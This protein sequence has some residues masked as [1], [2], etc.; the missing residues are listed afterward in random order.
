M[1]TLLLRDPQI[2]PE[3]EVLEKALGEG[4]MVFD[5]LV[6][7]ITGEPFGLETDW[8]YYKDGKA[9][10]CKVRYKK[11]TIFWLSVWDNFFKTTFYFTEKTGAG[12]ANLEIDEELKESFKNSRN[13]GRLIPL[14]ISMKSMEQI[15]DLIK[16]LQYKKSIK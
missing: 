13:I 11:K 3:K 10:L 16:I 14:T 5:E 1:E 9:W 15:G 8:N 6:K 4:F 7:K 2:S 12:I